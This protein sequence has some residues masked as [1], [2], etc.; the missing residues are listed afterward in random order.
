MLGEIIPIFDTIKANRK[1][2]KKNEV[3]EFAVP[4]D[5]D[6]I[7]YKSLEKEY[8][9]T[10]EMKNRFEDKAKTIIASLTIAITLIL[11]L[12]SVIGNI[13]RKFQFVGVDVLIFTLSIMAIIYMLMAGLSCIMLIAKENILYKI[14]LL[15]ISR[16]SRKCL[17]EYIQLNINQN[18]IRNNIIFTAYRSIRNSVIC[19][20]LIF[21]FA[22]FPYSPNIINKSDDIFNEQ[23]VLYSESA[24]DWIVKNRE[25]DFMIEYFVNEYMTSGNYGS[26]SLYCT[27]ENILVEIELRDNVYIIKKITDNIHVIDDF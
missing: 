4:D 1:L 19:L 5:F 22:I 18:L 14:P 13:S 6:K 7:S 27:N 2:K 8:E 3:L 25:K 15:D 24:M 20:F 11:N 23:Q 10:I 21:I 26:R 12:S 16:K 9:D 17:Y